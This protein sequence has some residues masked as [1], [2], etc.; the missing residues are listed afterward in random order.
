MIVRE[1]TINDQ[2]AIWGIF[3]TIVKDGDAYAF[4]PDTTKDDLPQIWLAPGMK[5]FVVEAN[6]KVLGSYFIRPN[7]PGL[8]SHIANCGYI[9]HPEARGKGLGQQLCVHSIYTARQLGYKGMQYNLVVSTNLTAVNLWERC[10]FKI[11]GTIPKGFNHKTLGYVDAH[12][13][14]REI[15]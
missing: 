5:T 12:I 13:M 8:G 3:E 7:Q 4:S 2:D 15:D 9:V 10:G 11:I 1:A 14:F 6:G